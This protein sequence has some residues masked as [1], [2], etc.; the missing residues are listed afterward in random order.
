MDGLETSDR[1]AVETGTLQ[2]EIFTELLHRYG[3][4]LQQARE[5]SELQVDELDVLFLN[6]V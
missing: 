2:K 4:V 1:G 5:V 3:E 6:D